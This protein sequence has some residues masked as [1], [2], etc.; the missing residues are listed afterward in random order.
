M[1]AENGLASG[2][3]SACR[4]LEAQISDPVGLEVF[5]RPCAL[6]SLAGASGLY[7]A[8]KVDGTNLPV[9]AALCIGLTR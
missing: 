4:G 8:L 9:G 5:R 6:D 3:Y 7:I 1:L 2:L